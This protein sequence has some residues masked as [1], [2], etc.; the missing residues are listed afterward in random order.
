MTLNEA[1]LAMKKQI[2][3]A[4]S[5]RISTLNTQITEEITL[6][7]GLRDAI[8]ALPEGKYQILL[9][10]A[11]QKEAKINDLTSHRKALDEAKCKIFY[12]FGW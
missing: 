5:L 9:D 8:S 1:D 12:S 4:L 2:L 10:T 11:K 7:D 3:E 6:L